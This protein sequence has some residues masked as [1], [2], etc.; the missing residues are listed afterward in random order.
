MFCK[1]QKKVFVFGFS[2]LMLINVLKNLTKEKRVDILYWTGSKKY[3]DNLSKN[4][5][6]FSDTIF[7][8]TFDVAQGIGA[9]GVDL[10]KSNFISREIIG[11]MSRYEAQVLEMMNAIDLNGAS[12]SKKRHLYHKYLIYWHGVLTKYKPDVILFSDIPHVAFLFVVYRL[13]RIMSIKIIIF[14]PLIIPGRLIFLNDF[15]SYE[16]IEKEFIKNDKN[17]KIDDLSTDIKNYYLNQLNK[18]MDSMPFYV[19]NKYT[20]IIKRQQK[21][22]PSISNIIKHVYTLSFI[23][24]TLSYAKTFRTNKRLVS[25]DGF[26]YSGFKLKFK[27]KQWVK[28]KN[29]FKKEYESL[30]INKVDFSKKYIY[31]ALHNQPECSTSAMG[32]IFT[33]QILMI[34][35]IASSLPKGWILYVKES[36][37]Q[38]VHSRGHLG[39]YEGYYNE[40]A[41]I[42]NVT[43]IPVKISSFKLIENSQA[44]ATVTG[45][46]AWEAVLRNKPGLVFGDIW[47]KYC[48]GIYI[49]NDVDTC[50]RAINKIQ[51]GRVLDRQ[52]IINYLAS[53]NKLSIV[54]YPNKKLKQKG[55]TEEQNIKNIT[56]RL[57]EE[58]LK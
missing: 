17:Y 9:E 35:M 23:K 36:P 48:E 15:N 6:E 52:K 24:T 19:K 10:S 12:L 13:A 26:C 22:F 25:I 4:K 49:V 16:L 54:G 3:F 11:K 33:D 2:K 31:L 14:K 56:N 58:L 43:L 41:K 46:V 55:I 30:Q 8:S 47:Y 42:N 38:W 32:G 40:I 28:I 27:I 7:H 45:S 39:R 21:F 5:K 50:K 44:V 20:K 1:T 18:K 29:N 37:L 34:E 51:K 53:V 57:S